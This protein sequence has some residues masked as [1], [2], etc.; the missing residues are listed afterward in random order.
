M[1]KSYLIAISLVLA[2]TGWMLS[3]MLGRDSPGE[4]EPTVTKSERTPETMTVQ[5]RT[6]QASPIAREI[7]IQGE[8]EPNR[9]VTLQAE[10]AGQVVELVAERGQRVKAGD[11][12]LRLKMND[13][14]AQLRQAQA[15]VQQRERD[16]EATQ[17]LGQT[18]YQARTLIDQAMAELQAARAALERIRLDME[19]TV[20]RAP[21]EGILNDRPVE[22]GTV[23]AI[24]DP[25]ATLVDD[26]PLI[27]TGQAPQ[28]AM[29]QLSVGQTATVRFVTGRQ[30]EGVIRYISATADTATRTFRIEVEVPN[31]DG[32]LIAGISGELRIPVETV[33]THFLSPALLTLDSEGVLGIKVVNGDERVEFYP[34]SIVR[35]GTKGVWVAGLPEQARLITVGQGFVQ[36]G[37]QVTAVPGTVSVAG[38]PRQALT[39]VPKVAMT[40]DRTD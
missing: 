40:L 6:Q 28:Q 2:L 20:I 17:K 21:F 11:V 5:V 12:I 8:A 32:S 15:L 24:N 1:N 35:A 31:P 13:R 9:I 33:S 23:V 37:E 29:G 27:V 3:G 19:N 39:A 26:S 38:E 22:I 18:G 36:A 30:G 10:T 4:Q 14:E 7:V 16:F 34:V 25:V